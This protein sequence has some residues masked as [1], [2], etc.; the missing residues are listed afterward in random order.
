MQD[1]TLFSLGYERQRWLAARVANISNNVAN[2][3]NP[4]FKPKDVPS[5]ETLL[6]TGS[7]GLGVARTDAAH[8]SP[9][10]AGAER[11]GA[12]ERSGTT[13]KHSGNAVSLETEMAALGQAR[14]HQA[15]ATA[16]LGAFHRMLLSSTKG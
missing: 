9:P 7:S 8:L 2:A 12:I 5:F 10:D 4:G 6:Q 16:I 13:E 3:D 11:Y 14:G 1:L 15:S